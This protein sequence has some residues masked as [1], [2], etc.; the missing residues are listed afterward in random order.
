MFE[1]IQILSI[2]KE[3]KIEFS[4]RIKNFVEKNSSV[5]DKYMFYLKQCVT[6]TSTFVH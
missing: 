4:E 3:Q 2:K 6:L 1:I 5:I